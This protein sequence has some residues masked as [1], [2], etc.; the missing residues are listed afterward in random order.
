MCDVSPTHALAHARAHAQNQTLTVQVSVQKWSCTVTCLSR[1][2]APGSNSSRF[3]MAWP[4]RIFE[5]QTDCRT[6][7]R[8][9]TRRTICTS[10]ADAGLSTSNP[11]P[12][13]LVRDGQTSPHRPRLVVSR[14]TCPP[15]SS[16]PHA[17][18]FVLGPA[19]IKHTPTGQTS[20]HRLRLVVSHSTCPPLSFS[21]SR[22][23][24]STRSCS[25]EQQRECSSN[26]RWDHSGLLVLLLLSFAVRL[27]L[28]I[29]PDASELPSLVDRRDGERTLRERAM[30]VVLWPSQWSGQAIE[31]IRPSV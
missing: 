23:Q 6:R 24:L 1:M 8:P 12:R 28:M 30:R 17:N 18:S 29:G 27:C 20:P 13:S 11:K 9:W 21:P 4:W 26:L 10:H 7:Q 16:P 2:S 22:A 14:S 5:P 19:V 31:S 25:T 3:A 15:P